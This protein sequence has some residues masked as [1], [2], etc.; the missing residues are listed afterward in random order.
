MSF[1]NPEAQR[2]GEAISAVR[3]VMIWQQ[4]IAQA[5]VVRK[6]PDDFS[7]KERHNPSRQY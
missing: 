4:K 1:R 3:L 5:V 2:L 7:I 6:E